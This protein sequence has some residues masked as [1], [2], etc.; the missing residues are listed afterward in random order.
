M[1]IATWQKNNKY[2]VGYYRIWEFLE[3]LNIKEG[4]EVMEIPYLNTYNVEGVMKRLE[5]TDVVIL[6]QEW[7]EYPLKT[8]RALKNANGMDKI[9]SIKNKDIKYKKLHFVYT[10][11]DDI[12]NVSPLVGSYKLWGK[13]NW[14]LG[15][16][17]VWESGKTVRDNVLFEANGNRKAILETLML[18]KEC[19]MVVCTTNDLVRKYRRFN[20]NTVMVPNGI[21][22]RFFKNKLE[23]DTDK[24]R[25]FWGMSP[26]HYEDWFDIAGSIGE[27]LKANPNTILV[28]VGQKWRDERIPE[29]QREHHGVILDV[30]GYW[31]LLRALKIDIGLA[32]LK[33]KHFNN[34][35]N[36]YKSPLK[37]EEYSANRTPAL[38]PR[39]V[40]PKYVKEDEAVFYK[41]KEEFKEKLQLLI[42]DKGLRKKVGE[43]GYETVKKEYDTEKVVEIYENKLKNMIEKKEVVIV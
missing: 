22:T 38:L 1:K 37:W 25:I 16:T 5:G 6:G 18:M 10:L 32:H 15:D 11:D 30:R 31:V 17:W 14:K 2:A 28:T 42:D 7:G 26:S 34:I 12:L 13:K 20:K 36:K 29:T 35:F 9:A 4:Y 39:I 33:D 23:N 19:D 41:D 40:Y 27:V 43:K 8:V 24:I 21:D 3:R